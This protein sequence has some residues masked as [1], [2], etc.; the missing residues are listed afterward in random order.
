MND[1][2]STCKPFDERR[3]M[4]LDLVLGTGKPRTGELSSIDKLLSCLKKDD[5]ARFATQELLA[6]KDVTNHALGQVIEMKSMQSTLNDSRRCEEAAEMLLEA[7][8]NRKYL[9]LIIEHVPLYRQDA[10]EMLLGLKP[11]RLELRCIIEHVP[12]YREEAAEMLLKLAVMDD[13]HVTDLDK[14]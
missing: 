6:R 1:S 11:N 12:L 13:K 5:W 10:A 8:G 2:T 3:E 4:W 9:P 7:E 14:L